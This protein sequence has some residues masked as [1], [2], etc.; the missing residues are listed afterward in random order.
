LRA[1]AMLFERAQGL[2]GQTIIAD[3]DARLGTTRVTGLLAYESDHALGPGGRLR[4]RAYGNYHVSHFVDPHARINAVATDARDW[5]WTNGAT[6]DG[7]WQAR[8]WLQLTGVLDGRYDRFVPTDALA[9]NATGAPG[10]RRFG[11]AGL[12]GDLWSRS[13]R[14]DVMASLRVEAA[15]EQ[16]SGRNAFYAMQPTSS[17]VTHTLPIARLALVERVAPWLCLRMNAGRYARLPS[18]IELYGNTGYLLGNTGLRPESGLNA[19]LGPAVAWQSAHVRLQ[20]DVAAFANWVN[21]LIAYQIGGGHARADNVGRARIL[22]IESSANL[23]VGAHARLVASATLTDARDATARETYHDRQLP[24]RP[25]YRLYARPEWRAIALGPRSALGVYA[26]VDATAGNYLDP[27]NTR[28]VAARLL[29]G[30]GL[31]ADLPGGFGLRL[32][33]RNLADAAVYDFAN[34]PLPGREVY[35]TLAWSSVNHPRKE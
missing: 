7:Q 6:A 9:T 34:Y 8:S 26:D 21:D 28:P 19:D 12:E 24:L 2:P 15:H 23:E 4:A 22:G 14:L 31:Y 27:A 25:R 1:S 29:V 10:S 16:T 35:L 32:R 18:L 30:A 5:T 11:A 17:A 3:P 13:L 33:G 20:L